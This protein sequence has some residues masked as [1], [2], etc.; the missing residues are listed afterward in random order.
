MKTR[1]LIIFFCMVMLGGMPAA[2]APTD[3]ARID[4]LAAEA[5]AA[6]PEIEVGRVPVPTKTAIPPTPEPTLAPGDTLI[7]PMDGME[8]VYVP[9]GEFTMGSNSDKGNEG[10]EHRVTLD[11]YMIDKTEVTNAMYAQCVAEGACDPPAQLGSSS[12]DSYY[13][14]SIYADYPAIHVNWHEAKAYCEWAGRQLPTEAQWEKTARGTNGLIYPWGDTSPTSDLANYG[15]KVGDTTE[16]CSYPDGNSP[17]GACDMAGN[18]TEWVADK[19]DYYYYGTS[20]TNNPTGPADGN[21]RSMRGGSWWSGTGSIRSASRDG[22]G[23]GYSNQDYGFRC[24]L[25][26]P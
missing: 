10:P 18:V 24:S 14:N 16:V 15:D 23:P 21:D 11:G 7:S 2:C 22:S 6:L 13:D 5:V 1:T 3:K 26:L 9:E 20:P 19:Y 4:T 12:Q 17:Y 8:M 25:S